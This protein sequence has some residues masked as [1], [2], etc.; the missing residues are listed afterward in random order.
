MQVEAAFPAGGEALELVRQ[1][2]GLLHDVAELARALD[3]ALALA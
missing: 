3:V 2:K 1:G